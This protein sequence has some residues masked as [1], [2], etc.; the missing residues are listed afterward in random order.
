MDADGNPIED[1]VEPGIEVDQ[2]AMENEAP[3]V[4]HPEGENLPAIQEH[5]QIPL[6]PEV[7]IQLPAGMLAE[8]NGVVG[9]NV[10]IA[11]SGLDSL[12]IESQIQSKAKYYS[13]SEP[14]YLAQ[15]NDLS[16][17]I[18]QMN[19]RLDK[20]AGTD[21][22]G[23]KEFRLSFENLQHLYNWSDA[24]SKHK[25]IASLTGS[26][27]SHIASINIKNLNT[28]GIL[29]L[30]K[31]RFDDEHLIDLNESRFNTA[32]KRKAQTWLDFV[33]E[34]NALATKA[35]PEFNQVARERM[36]SR[37]LTDHIPYETLKTHI[38]I[39]HI[40]SCEKI[41]SLIMEWPALTES[42]N[43]NACKAGPVAQSGDAS[44]IR[45]LCNRIAQLENRN[46][47]IVEPMEYPENRVAGSQNQRC[48]QCGSLAHI[49]RDCTLTGVLCFNCQNVGHFARDCTLE[50]K[51]PMHMF[52]QQTGQG[53]G[54]GTTRPEQ[55]F[56]RGSDRMGLH[57]PL[58]QTPRY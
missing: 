57:R 35:F 2:P 50:K 53:R 28:E 47:N 4:E 52:Q 20:F 58:N 31:A 29:D 13:K 55:D 12:T 7:N 22:M 48:R 18:A 25:L 54:R 42:A 3:I 27:L 45:Q 19:D 49:T 17:A 34:L 38:K 16:Q 44:M 14:G 41:C 15:L 32:V 43:S 6:E 56:Q 26:A 9:G 40:K 1:Q 8:G 36:V 30:L 11:H 51:T 10:Q 33:S 39:N 24:Q 46:S 37:K 23:F 5:Q 21:K